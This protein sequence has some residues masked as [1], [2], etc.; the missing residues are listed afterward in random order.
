MGQV[1][2]HQLSRTAQRLGIANCHHIYRP[3]EQINGDSDPLEAARLSGARSAG[4]ARSTPRLS[5]ARNV[6]VHSAADEDPQC[7]DEDEEEEKEQEEMQGPEFDIP[8]DAYGG[9]ILAIVQYLPNVTRGDDKA[10]N[11]AVSIMALGLLFMNLLLQLAILYYVYSFV[12]QP[13][14]RKVQLQYMDYRGAV[15]SSTG[16]FDP[17]EWAAYEGKTDLCEIALTDRAFYY[18]ILFCWTMSMLREIRISEKFVRDIKSMP[19]TDNPSA[20]LITHEEEHQIFIVALTTPTRVILNMFVCAPKIVISGLLLWLG[21]QWL[22]AT[23]SFTDLVMN[24]VAMEFVLTIDNTLYDAFLPVWYREEVADVN[25]KLKDP[26]DDSPEAVAKQKWSGMK[27]SF[28]YA[29]AAIFYILIYAEGV[30]NVL[31]AD[32]SEVKVPCKDFIDLELRQALC[33]VSSWNMRH[34]DNVLSC[35]PYGQPEETTLEER[36]D[37]GG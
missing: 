15:F 21:C 10:L 34:M 6:D 5:G 20:M 7:G 30:Q 4:S 27:R 12:V 19:H 2:G 22:S 3:Y 13:A 26:A 16:M 18:S 33:D 24:A 11:F 28:W 17:D 37:P 14:V 9:A 29:V 1:L 23:T 25:F 36:G 8:E 35:Y 32:L 31:P